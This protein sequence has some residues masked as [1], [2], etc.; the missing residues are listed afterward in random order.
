MGNKSKVIAIQGYRGSFHEIVAFQYFPDEVFH[1]LECESF[2]ELVFAVKEKKADYGIM[3]IENTVASSILPNYLLLRE[4][5]LQIL[6]EC[7]IHIQQNL[8]ALPGQTIK[9]IHTVFSHPMAINQCRKF[10]RDYKHIKLV[11]DVDTALSAKK[12]RKGKL[13]GIGAIASTLASEIYEL[14]NLA[15]NIQR[16]QLNYTRFLIVAPKENKRSNNKEA[17]KSSIC[18]TLSHKHGSLA[19]VL[20]ELAK[21]ESNLTKIHSLPIVGK[22]WEY[23]FYVDLVFDNY[24]KFR[25]SLNAIK[26][27]TGE[28]EVLGEYKKGEQ[29]YEN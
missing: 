7:N 23:M 21:Y 17:N 5:N 1:T 18:F 19:E 14:E 16:N 24:L 15:E 28:L 12:I 9:D 4:A 6:G 26:I 11:E 3:A 25:E 29:V 20:T 22:P 8:M 27:F 2:D 10:F 13:K